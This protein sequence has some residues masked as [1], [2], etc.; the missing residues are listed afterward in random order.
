MSAGADL[1]R[2]LS[3]TGAYQLTGSSPLD[4]ELDAYAEGLDAAW[5]QVD[6]VLAELFIET[7][8][9][10]TLGQ[11]EILFHGQALPGEPADRRRALLG[12]LGAYRGPGTLAELRRVAEAAGIDGAV[13]E[14]ETG[15]I[16]RAKG[17]LGVSETEARR[18]L[19]RLMPLH[20]NW[21]LIVETE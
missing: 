18:L 11:W 2:I 19:A 16:I 5:A 20:L 13:E 15:V 7:A 8:P 12:L 14:T 10:E 3:V 9:E 21:E 17:F 1:R 6:R 4:W